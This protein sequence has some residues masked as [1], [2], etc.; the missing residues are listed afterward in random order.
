MA[1]SRQCSKCDHRLD[2]VHRKGL[3]N[4]LYSDVYVC[5]K[6]HHRVGHN[7]AIEALKNQFAFIFSLYTRCPNCA[8]EDT[9]Q[10]LKKRDRIDSRSKSPFAWIQR[11]LGAPIVRCFPC[12]LQYYDWRPLRQEWKKPKVGKTT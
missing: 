4:L 12:R 10:R 2:R 9:L 8:G 5:V 11:L 3:E 7:R 1:F 6:C